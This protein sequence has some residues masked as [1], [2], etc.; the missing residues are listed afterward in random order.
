VLILAHVSTLPACTEHKGTVKIT[1]TWKRKRS[2]VLR[3]E[4]WGF[5]GDEIQVAVFWTVMWDPTYHNPEDGGLRLDV[6]F[7]SQIARIFCSCL[8]HVN[9]M[10]SIYI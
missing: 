7:P 1:D 8:W 5:H 3:Y 4:V 9:K 2:F 6:A 10:H